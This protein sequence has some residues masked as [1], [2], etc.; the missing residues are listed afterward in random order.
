[1]GSSKSLIGIEMRAEFASHHTSESDTTGC[2]QGFIGREK[3]N[4]TLIFRMGYQI[5]ELDGS[6]GRSEY[7]SKVLS[8]ITSS[9]EKKYYQKL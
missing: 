7:Y 2:V 1:M 4:K 5:Y 9:V 3:H 6:D 8:V